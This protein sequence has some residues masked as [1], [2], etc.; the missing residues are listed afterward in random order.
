M[1]SD[2]LDASDEG[3]HTPGDDRW[4]A[5][6]FTFDFWTDGGSLGGYA[7]I[8]ILPNLRRAWY[9]AA[10]VGAGRPLITVVDLDVLL[11]RARLEIRSDALW[12]DHVCETPF[13]HWTVSNEAIA[14]ALDDPS[15][16]IGLARGTPTPLGFDLEWEAAA[17]PVSD[18]RARFY[19]Q[20]A[21]VHGEVLVGPERLEIDAIGTRSHG[22]AVGRWWERATGAEVAGLRAPFVLEVNGDRF[23]VERVLGP[24]GWSE[25]VRPLTD[26]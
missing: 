2:P 1:E 22:W 7:S 12:A 23:V 25:W 8:T 20:D 15:D 24:G 6:S 21:S 3:R 26:P 17:A 10:L 4:W 13:D 9:W 16:A 14:V 11:P 19:R 18:G 5:E